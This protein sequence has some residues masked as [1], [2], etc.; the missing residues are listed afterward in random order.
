M[1]WKRIGC[2]VDFSPEARVALE[3]AALLA[4]RYGAGLTLLHVDDRS[5]GP[6]TDAT[7]SG[8]V[9]LARGALE[10]ERLLGEWAE[11]ARRI[12]SRPVEFLLLAGDPASAIVKAAEVQPFDVVV[13]GTHGRAELD[14]LRFGS[15][16]Q[17]V[18]RDAPCSVL[19]VRRT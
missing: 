5:E 12:T 2:A 17:A 11:E 15:V 14:R 3:Q 18:V 19:V 13:M 7:L 9:S 1:S 8:S 16:A 6:P 4:T 10:L